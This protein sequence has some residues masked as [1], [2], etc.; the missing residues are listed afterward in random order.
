MQYI[1]CSM[2]ALA[3][4]FLHT[5]ASW[6]EP[7][8]LASTL[9][10]MKSPTTI[11]LIEY[12]PLRDQKSWGTRP[13]GIS[14]KVGALSDWTWTLLTPKGVF[15]MLKSWK[16][17]SAN[18]LISVAVGMVKSWPDLT[19]NAEQIRLRVVQTVNLEGPTM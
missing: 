6:V 3:P 7:A 15:G 9:R 4:E 10:I 16:R 17:S 11:T 5:W 18:L 19:T 8:Q 1:R 2:R 13:A 12:K 14:A